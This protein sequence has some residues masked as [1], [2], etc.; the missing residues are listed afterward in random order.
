MTPSGHVHGKIAAR[1]AGWLAPFV[2]QHGLGEA[3][4]AETGFILQRAP[5]TVR[6]PDAAFVTTARLAAINP[7]PEGYFPGP[8][9][10]AVEVVSP[11]DAFS[12]VEAKVA[13]W[14]AS[15]TQAVVVVDP[16]RKAAAVHRPDGRVL[17]LAATDVLLLPDL[18][19]GWSL[20]LA[21]LFR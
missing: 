19:P 7:S 20:P 13:E 18:L 5:D 21:E 12:A 2:Q 16:Q 14:L 1:V 4:G 11:S 6:A 3:Y 9:D 17:S 8:P 10:L 15:G